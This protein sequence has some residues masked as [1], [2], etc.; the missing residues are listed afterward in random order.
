[1]KQKI[2]DRLKI[3]QERMAQI[4]SLKQHPTKDLGYRNNAN[5]EGKYL[6]LEDEHKWLTNMLSKM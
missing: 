1:M 3:V 2:Q 4:V 6:M 5:L